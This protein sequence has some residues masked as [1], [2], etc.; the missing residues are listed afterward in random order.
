MGAGLDLPEAIISHGH[1]TVDGIKMSKS[2]NN[3]VN[4]ER[5]IDMYGVEAFRFFLL[6]EGSLEDDSNYSQ[7][8]LEMNVNQ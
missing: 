6:N 8:L 5:V 3:V 1:W 7:E 4:P 2:L